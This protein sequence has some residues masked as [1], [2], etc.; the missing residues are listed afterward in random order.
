MILIRMEDQMSDF[1]PEAVRQGLEAARK[2]ALRKSSRLR[3][4]DGDRMYPILRLWDRGFSLEAEDAPHLRGLVDIFDGGRHLYQ[5][6]IIASDEENGEM[7]YEF[8][9]NT[10]AAD[11]APLDFERA[12][13]APIALLGR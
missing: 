6:L 3:I 4:M 7:R 9:R 2:D 12:D 13:D 5:C 10:A 8:K 11:K 1:L